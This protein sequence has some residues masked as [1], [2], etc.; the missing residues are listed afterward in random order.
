MPA[1]NYD[2]VDYSTNKFFKKNITHKDI[3]QKFETYK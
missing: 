3:C 2:L 1:V